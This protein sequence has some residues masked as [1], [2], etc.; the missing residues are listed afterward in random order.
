[1]RKIKAYWIALRWIKSTSAS[2]I[3]L[4]HLFGPSLLSSERFQILPENL[5]DPGDHGRHQS[6]EQLERVWPS[7]SWIR[8]GSFHQL[9]NLSQLSWANFRFWQMMRGHDVLSCLLFFCILSVRTITVFVFCKLRGCGCDNGPIDKTFR[10]VSSTCL[11]FPKSG[12]LDATRDIIGISSGNWSHL[13][14]HTSIEKHPVTNVMLH[15]LL[16][17]LLTTHLRVFFFFYDLVM[18]LLF[19]EKRKATRHFI[20]GSAR[21]F[22]ILA[23]VRSPLGFVYKMEREIHSSVDMQIHSIVKFTG[24]QTLPQVKQDLVR[25]K[26]HVNGSSMGWV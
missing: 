15:L 19:D 2:V 21:Y 26:R 8:Q 16:S 22:I 17:K 14:F 6:W 18:H 23:C 24:Y 5:I 1:M 25:V 13:I 7:F 10:W 20:L 3:C 4:S 12:A 11:G 9:C